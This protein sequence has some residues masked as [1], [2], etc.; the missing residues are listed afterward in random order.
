[1]IKQEEKKSK[2]A[3]VD[4]RKLTQSVVEKTLAKAK[5]AENKVMDQAVKEKNQKEYDL[6]AQEAMKDLEIDYGDEQ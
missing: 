2:K 6:A 4:I 1:M 3:E 5:A